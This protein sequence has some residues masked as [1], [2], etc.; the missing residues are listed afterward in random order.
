[1][2]DINIFG[3]KFGRLT[4]QIVCRASRQFS[5][6]HF[7]W[8]FWHVFVAKQELVMPEPFDLCCLGFG[9]SPSGGHNISWG[10]LCIHDDHVLGEKIGFE[11]IFAT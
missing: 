1:M 3:Y 10:L 11:E 4:L 5:L 8:A 2:V 6:L 9:F 7:C